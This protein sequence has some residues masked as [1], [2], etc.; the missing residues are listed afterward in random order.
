M[1]IKIHFLVILFASFYNGVL[2]QSFWKSLPPPKPEKASATFMFADSA[3]VTASSSTYFA[4]RPIVTA[5]VVYHK[6][7][8]SAARAGG[9]IS[10][11]NITYDFKSAKSYCNWAVSALAF[12]NETFS[13]GLMVSF[14]NNVLGI[15]LIYTGGKFNPMTTNNFNFNNGL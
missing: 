2:G 12:I 1:P 9:G 3:L 15:G 10:W 5:A 6:G 7:V 13:C 14:L 11:Q 4:F 8:P